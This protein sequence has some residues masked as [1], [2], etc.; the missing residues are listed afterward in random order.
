MSMN[1]KIKRE[2]AVSFSTFSRGWTALYSDQRATINVSHGQVS[3]AASSVGQGAVYD[4]RNIHEAKIGGVSE[5]R[6][7]AN[8]AQCGAMNNS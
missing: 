5:P 6:V 4:S 1:L 3:T 7:S 2:D 8:L